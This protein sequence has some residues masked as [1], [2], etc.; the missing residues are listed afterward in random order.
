MNLK[1]LYD[2][3]P[4]EKHPNIS[5]EGNSVVYDDGTSVYQM[6]LSNESTLI[7]INSQTRDFLNSL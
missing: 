2:K 1:E 5:V 7:P 3:V 4:V 6:L